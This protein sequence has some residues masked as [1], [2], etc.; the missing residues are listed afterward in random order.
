MAPNE[1]GR[2][3]SAQRVRA[4]VDTSFCLALI[5]TRSRSLTAALEMYEPG[6][7]A[8]SAM[9]LAALQRRVL[10]S[11]EPARN[12]LAL[13]QFLLALEVVEFGAQAAGALATLES[14]AAVGHA[15]SAE[16]LMTAAQAVVLEAEVMTCL[17]Q[18]YAALPDVRL[19]P[20]APLEEPR[21]TPLTAAMPM[22]HVAAQGVILAMGSHDLTLD[23]LGERLHKRDPRL[24]FCTAHVGSMDGLLALQRREAHLAGAHLLDEE[25]GDYNVGHVRRVL[26]SQGVRVVLV[27]FVG[28]VQGLIVE[29]GNPLDIRSVEDLARDDV[30]F[31]NRQPGAGTRLLLDHELRRRA[32][33]PDQV[34]GY[35][36][37]EGSH[38]AVAAAVA[39]GAADCALGIQA[40]AQAHGLDFVPLSNERYDLVIPV[41]HYESALLAP[42]LTLLRRPDADFLQAVAALGGY[43]TESMG[44][45]LAEL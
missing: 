7:V 43:T 2:V 12:R 38:V 33:T 19:L 31:V 37:E 14:M 28:R 27:G 6:E 30:R 25:T 41:E 24:L 45:V 9:T 42:L 3:S 5:A 34:T 10:R 11:R 36:R 21:P 1:T 13:E 16:T 15:P 44:K 29:R 26:S 17:P 22:A 32:M 35:A 40:A 39:S 4:L 18:Q 23:L 8:I 20:V